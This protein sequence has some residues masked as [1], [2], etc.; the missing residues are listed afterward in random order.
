MPK[1]FNQ[2][3][4]DN[5]DINEKVFL[6]FISFVIMLLFAIADVITG[7]LN[8]P[9][10]IHEYVYESFLI[11]TIGAFGIGSVDKF[12]NRKYKDKPNNSSTL[13]DDDEFG[14]NGG[15]NKKNR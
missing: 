14:P 4:R 1:F 15:F 10:E 2:L 6:G 8:V 3:F 7:I 9:F 11:L 5:N 13:D 12:V